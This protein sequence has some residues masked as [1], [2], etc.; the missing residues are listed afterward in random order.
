M[1]NSNMTWELVQKMM[2]AGLV[3]AHK[4]REGFW[5]IENPLTEGG[6][7]ISLMVFLNDEETEIEECR[8]FKYEH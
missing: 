7:S 8:T 5:V 6:E 4:E 1:K 2:E 3:R